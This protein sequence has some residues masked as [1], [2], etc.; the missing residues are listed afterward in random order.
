[1]IVLQGIRQILGFCQPP[2]DVVDVEA[3][4]SRA[5]VGHVFLRPLEHQ[6][7]YERFQAIREK[8]HDQHQPQGATQNVWILASKPRAMRL[9]NRRTMLAKGL[10][11]QYLRSSSADV[12]V[13]AEW[14]RS[15]IWAGT[16]RVAAAASAS[17]NPLPQHKIIQ[18][19]TD[20][21]QAAELYCFNVSALSNIIGDTEAK[22][23]TFLYQSR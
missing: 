21:D 13:A 20:P 3:Y 8:L 1:M 15:L 17:L 16:R 14:G 9:R 5:K 4:S 22:I 2:L 19:S 18:L 6:A 12:E 7:S 10:V 23:E 11:Q